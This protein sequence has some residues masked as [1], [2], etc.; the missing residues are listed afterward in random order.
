MQP[1]VIHTGLRSGCGDKLPG[2][3]RLFLYEII[4]ILSIELKRIIQLKVQFK[5][6]L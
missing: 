3:S 4:V 2:K 5:L 1:H 6:T